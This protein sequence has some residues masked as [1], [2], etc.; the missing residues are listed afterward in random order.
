MWNPLVELLCNVQ[1]GGILEPFVDEIELE[2]IALSC[3]FALDVLCD[4]KGAH[5]SA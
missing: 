1:I 3:H 2:R 5:A 4:M